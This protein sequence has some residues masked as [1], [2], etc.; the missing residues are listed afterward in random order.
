[1][2]TSND[3]MCNDY[4]ISLYFKYLFIY[5]LVIWVSVK[6]KTVTMANTHNPIKIKIFLSTIAL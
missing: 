5:R 4:M 1:M 6:N 2:A 3:N